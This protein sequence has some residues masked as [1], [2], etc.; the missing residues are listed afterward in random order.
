MKRCLGA[1]GL[2]LAVATAASAT[3]VTSAVVTRVREDP[4]TGRVFVET[5]PAPATLACV[6]TLTAS[7]TYFFDADTPGGRALFAQVLV[8]KSSQ[9]KVAV[10]GTSTCLTLGVSPL[11]VRY[12]GVAFI[13]ACQTT[14]C[15]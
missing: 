1:M 10:T 8:A 2:T 7:E 15:T 11:T 4:A 5:S 12:E 14:P 9:R 13:A 3:S 6:G